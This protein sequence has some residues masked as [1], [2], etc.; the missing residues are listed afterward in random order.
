[1]ES[2]YDKDGKPKKEDLKFE[3]D[4]EVDTDEKGLTVLKAKFCQQYQR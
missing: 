1:M 2:L 4:E 3:E